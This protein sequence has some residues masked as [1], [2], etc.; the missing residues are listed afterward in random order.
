MPGESCKAAFPQAQT[1]DGISRS[2]FY[3]SFMDMGIVNYYHD[4]L[5]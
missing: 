4:S 3:L 2:A 5:G 1:Q